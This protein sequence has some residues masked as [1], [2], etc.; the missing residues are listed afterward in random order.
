[1]GSQLK[2]PELQTAK[3]VRFLEAGNRARELRAQLAVTYA[4]S[5]QIIDAMRK[6]REGIPLP[7]K[8][9]HLRLS[10]NDIDDPEDAS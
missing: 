2:K 7:D 6:L 9:Q 10:A 5:T 8:S 3:E 4:A 1:M